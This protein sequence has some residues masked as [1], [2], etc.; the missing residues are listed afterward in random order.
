MQQKKLDKLQ[1]KLEIQ[2]QV[3]NDYQ[4]LVQKLQTMNEKKSR[5]IKNWKHKYELMLLPIK[6]EQIQTNQTKIKKETK[7][8]E[9]I[10]LIDDEDEDEDEDVTVQ[11]LE[12]LRIVPPEKTSRD[13]FGCCT[14]EIEVKEDDEDEDEDEDE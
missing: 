3:L 6:Q 10:N 14:E 5:K 8:V 13:R 2:S 9:C 11:T 7:T 1:R 12:P 4:L